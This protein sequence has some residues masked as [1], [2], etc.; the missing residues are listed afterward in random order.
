MMQRGFNGMYGINQFG[1][2]FGPWIIVA[3]VLKLVIFFLII[4]IVY[5]IIK[6]H[7]FHSISAIRI[8]NERYAKGE[9]EEEEYLKRKEILRKK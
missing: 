3:M 9:I 1:G 8:L 6:K 5:K 4:F 7:N 2:V